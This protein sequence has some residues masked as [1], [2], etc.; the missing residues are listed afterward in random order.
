MAAAARTIL[1]RAGAMVAPWQAVS[2]PGKATA[3]R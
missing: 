2:H 1:V 3:Y